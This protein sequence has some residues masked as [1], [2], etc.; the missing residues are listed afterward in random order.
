MVSRFVKEVSDLIEKDPRTVLLL[1][2]I[3]QFSFREVMGKYPKRAFDIGIMEDCAV[4]VAAGISASGL[5]PFLHTWAPFL[6]ERTYEQLKLD[7]GAQDLQGNFISAGASYD[8]TDFGESHYCPADVPILKQIPRMEIIVPGTAEELGRLLVGTYDDGKP[9]YYRLSDQANERSYEV[10]FGKA[11]VIRRGSRGT[12]IAVGPMLDIILN[13]A[14][15]SDVT[16]LYYTTVEPFDIDTLKANLSGDKIMICEPYNSG[17]VLPDVIHGLSKE[18]IK[19]E[20]LG[21]D[22]TEF[23]KL[24]RFHENEGRWG[25]DSRTVKK[26]LQDFLEE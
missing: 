23:C 18:K 13:A 15:D 16:I 4:S 2:G 1:S 7:F 11:E 17:A 21:F 20:C 9:T 8:L 14:E 26:R 19:T 24:G 5:I 22:K 10:S 12:V 25:F 6:V 3:R